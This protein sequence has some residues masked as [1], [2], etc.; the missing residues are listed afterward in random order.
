MTRTP[1]ELI[2]R[3]GKTA[4]YLSGAFFVALGAINL[5]HNFLPLF[6]G[7]GGN[8]WPV[9]LGALLFGGLPL[10]FGVWLVWTQ[11]EQAP[12]SSQKHSIETHDESKPR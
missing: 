6:Q 12:A 2:A 4:G 8:W 9:L 5:V 7:A 11:G 1:A 3:I 10:G